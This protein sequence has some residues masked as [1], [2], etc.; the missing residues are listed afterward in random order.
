MI[1]SAQRH[2]RCG[3]WASRCVVDAQRFLERAYN[4]RCYYE[5]YDGLCQWHGC[6]FSHTQCKVGYR[7]V[8]RIFAR[9]LD[10]YVGGGFG[11]VEDGDSIK[12][13]VS[14][15]ML[16]RGVSYLRIGDRVSGLF[17]SSY[18]NDALCDVQVSGQF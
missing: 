16:G 18:P 14:V 8:D 9:V 11:F 1:V 10:W 17:R 6:P 7:P 3:V 12:Y 2:V 5:V 4:T 13:Y 15:S